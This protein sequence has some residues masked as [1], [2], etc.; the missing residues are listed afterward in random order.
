MWDHLYVKS[1]ISISNQAFVRLG[2]Y[3]EKIIS[4]DTCTP[5]LAADKTGKQ[6]QC[7]PTDEWMKTHRHN[8]ILS[9]WVRGT[10]A[11]PN[12]C[13][14][15]GYAVHEILQARIPEWGA[16]SLLQGIF[17]TQGSN[18]GLP[19][20]R[21]I[22]YSPWNITQSNGISLSQTEY[23]SVI[24]KGWTHPSCR[25]TDGLGGYYAIK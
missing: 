24:K 12:L 11:C 3:P 2:V 25:D 13:D 4:E 18:P 7:L 14:P 21:R 23:H 5:V 1:K 9:E 15:V 16:P 22:L 17:P 10:Q 8:G 6:A 19:H 20:C